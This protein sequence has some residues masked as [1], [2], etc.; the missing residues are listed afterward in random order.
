MA[1]SQQSQRVNEIIKCG[2]DPLYFMKTYAKVRTQS[3]GVVPFKTWPFQ[4]D[5][6]EAFVKHRLNIIKLYQRPK[7]DPSGNPTEA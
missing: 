2:R 7:A 5:C 4:D 1:T 3:A 6:V